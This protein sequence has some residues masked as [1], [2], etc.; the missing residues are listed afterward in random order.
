MTCAA[1]SPR[2]WLASV[3]SPQRRPRPTVAFPRR[4]SS[5]SSR[6]T[7]PRRRLHDVRPPRSRDARKT[8]LWR[9]EL[10]LSIQGQQDTMVA[11]RARRDHRHDVRRDHR[12]R[13]RMQLFLRP[14]LKGQSSRCHAHRARPTS[15]GL[16][17]DGIG[18][19]EYDSQIVKVRRRRANLDQPRPPLPR[20][21]LRSAS[22]S[23]RPIRRAS[24]CRAPRDGRMATHRSQCAPG[25]GGVSFQRVTVPDTTVERLAYIAAVHPKEPDRVYVRVDD[26]AG[27]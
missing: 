27:T 13:R 11:V 25:D 21:L 10:A 24:T 2:S 8:F 12:K 20:E 7:R 23:R 22:T 16:S 1:L 26:T 19:A 4:G 15:L 18:N 9:C 14:D 6:R 5:F 17:H 3:A